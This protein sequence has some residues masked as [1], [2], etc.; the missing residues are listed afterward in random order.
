M[1]AIVVMRIDPASSGCRTEEEN[2]FRVT[3][4]TANAAA[5]AMAAIERAHK[6]TAKHTFIN[7]S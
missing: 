7:I 3:E 6:E 5:H 4:E 2:N 1:S